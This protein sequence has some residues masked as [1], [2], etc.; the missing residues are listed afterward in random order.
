MARTVVK[1]EDATRQTWTGDT[2]YQNAL[3]IVAWQPTANTDYLV[4]WRGL[5]DN[6]AAG[7]ST[8]VQLYVETTATAPD[9]MATAPDSVSGPSDLCAVGGF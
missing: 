8:R 3:S 2:N 1:A 7:S 6:S 9:E 4:I 5:A